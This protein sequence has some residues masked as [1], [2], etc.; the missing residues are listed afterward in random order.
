MS[1]VVWRDEGARHP[2]GADHDCGVNEDHACASET[3][4]RLLRRSCGESSSLCLRSAR[5]NPGL[6]D[7]PENE[8]MTA[9]LLLATLLVTL[10]FPHKG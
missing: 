8:M 4:A 9:E 2:G 10:L 6:F 1:A 5:W 3:L 7:E